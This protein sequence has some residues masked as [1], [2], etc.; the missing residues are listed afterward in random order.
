MEVGAWRA[1][2]DIAVDRG[3]DKNA[4][5]SYARA[6]KSKF[7]AQWSGKGSDTGYS[8]QRA[9]AICEAHGIPAFDYDADGIGGAA[10]AH[11]ARLINEARSETQAALKGPTPAE[12]FAHG[13]IGTHPYRGSEA[14]VRPESIVPGTKRKAKDLFSN[15]KA[16]TCV[17]EGGSLGF[18]KRMEGAGNGKPYDRERG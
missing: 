12:Y 9:M 8:V 18:F 15:R 6:K 14:V 11:D 16:Q 1:A 7:A 13:T 3:N 10:V 5:R 17:H 2:L 4:Y